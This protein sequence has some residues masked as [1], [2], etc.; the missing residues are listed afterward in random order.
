MLLHYFPSREQKLSK[1]TSAAGLRVTV[2]MALAFLHE[3]ETLNYLNWPFS[4]RKHTCKW[5]LTRQIYIYIDRGRLKY[6]PVFS[7]QK[8]VSTSPI[9]FSG[10]KQSIK[11]QTNQRKRSNEG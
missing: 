9:F 7:Q 5:M 8:L 2:M 4:S 1:N 3:A 10:Y 11:R 6:G